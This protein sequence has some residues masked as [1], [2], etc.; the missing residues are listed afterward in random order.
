MDDRIREL[1]E[2]IAVLDRELVATAGRRVDV[3][4]ELWRIKD[5]HSLAP[6]DPEQERRL[7]ES[8]VAANDGALSDEGVRELAGAVL[9]LTKRELERRR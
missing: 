6:V 7:V 2:Q 5:E 4:A 8:L 1:R 3:V 9:A